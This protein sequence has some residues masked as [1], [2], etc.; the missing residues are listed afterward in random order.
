[1][2]RIKGVALAVCALLA[3]LG[4]ASP[5]AAALPPSV[6]VIAFSDWI[7]AYDFSPGL[8]T[9]EIRARPGGEVLWSGQAS[10]DPSGLCPPERACMQWRTVLFGV[11][12]QEGMEVRVAGATVT[13]SVV[14]VDRYLGVWRGGTLGALLDA[15]RPAG[16]TEMYF[17]MGDVH[18]TYSLSSPTT[19]PPLPMSAE[20]AAGTRVT[21]NLRDADGDLA[22]YELWSATERA[23]APAPAPPDDRAGPGEFAAPPSFGGGGVGSAVFLGGSVA[24]LEAAVRATGGA[25]AW[26]QDPSGR[27][28][29][30]LLGGPAFTNQPF[31]DAFPG[32]F[33]GPAAVFVTLR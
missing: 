1:M 29:R 23:P 21:A 3:A 11:D 19:T 6:H 24:Q 17:S 27:F 15:R 18:Y 31:V 10:E 14:V 20:V 2:L 12:L 30:L 7:A 32:G 22:L 5:A 13:K 8:L 26:V 9:V 33:A 4:T 25:G 16:F 28:F